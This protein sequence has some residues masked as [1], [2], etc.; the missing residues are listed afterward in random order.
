[1]S[2]Q[3]HVPAALPGEEEPPVPIGYEAGWAP[4]P[5]RATWRTENSWPCRDSNSDPSV[6]QPVASRYIPA[7]FGSD[8]TLKVAGICLTGTLV[9]GKAALY[10]FK[11]RGVLRWTD[12][13]EGRKK[14]RNR[15]KLN[16]EELHILPSSSIIIRIARLRRMSWVGH[17]LCEKVVRNPH[18]MLKE[19]IKRRDMGRKVPK[20][21]LEEQG[22]WTYVH[23]ARDREAVTRLCEQRTGPSGSIKFG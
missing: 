2:G 1:V 3:L 20:L 16:K 9:F 15:S 21:V 22:V 18:K 11:E 5:V 19:P 12:V 17:A 8:R 23:L 13:S 4:E 14:K 10:L 6:V 7:H